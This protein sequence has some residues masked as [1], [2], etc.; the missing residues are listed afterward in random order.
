M[1]RPLG[2]ILSEFENF[3]LQFSSGFES[4]PSITNLD[5]DNDLEIIIGTSQ[6]LSV[7]DI[8]SETNSEEFYW[9]TY[10]GDNHKTGYYFSDSI[11]GGDL[12]VDTLLNVLDLVV[13]INIIVGNSEATTSQLLAGDLNNDNNFDV[14]DI[15]ILVN[16]ILS[17][18]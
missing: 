17:E 16:L 1:K 6:N 13:A 7:I 12:N 9:N 5:N 10:R 2:E 15:V 8:K 3:P 4:S 11:L 14:L 18:N